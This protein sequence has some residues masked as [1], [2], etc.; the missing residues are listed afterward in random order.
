MLKCPGVIHFYVLKYIGNSLNVS[1]AA[2]HKE[3]VCFIKVGLK[4]KGYLTRFLMC[5][6]YNVR[7]GKMSLG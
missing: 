3:H 7:S 6:K 1:S 2:Q 5:R 4:C